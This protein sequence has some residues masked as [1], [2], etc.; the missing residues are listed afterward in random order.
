MKPKWI[1]RALINIEAMEFYIL[2][3]DVKDAL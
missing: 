2:V 1:R 3:M